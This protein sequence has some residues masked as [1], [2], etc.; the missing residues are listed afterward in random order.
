MSE[1]R[2]QDQRLAFIFNNHDVSPDCF[3]SQSHYLQHL[4]GYE[5]CEAF[6]GP[7][8]DLNKA[9]LHK[10]RKVQK[11][12]NSG[13]E[14]VDENLTLNSA[15]KSFS[16]AL[17]ECQD[18]RSRSGSLL[19]KSDRRKKYLLDLNN[20]VI[21]AKHSSSPR[22]G[23]MK[24]TTVTMCGA[25]TFPSPGTPNYRHSSVGIQKGWSSERV[26][27]YSASN[28][29]SQRNT[30]LLP[31]NTG[32]ALPFKWEDA[33]RWI[34]SPMSGYSS[35]QQPQR[36]PKSKSGPLI[37]PGRA[38]Y[39]FY[40]PAPPVLK[41]GN[42]GDLL[43]DSPFSSGVMA[44]DGLSICTGSNLGGGN[45][46]TNVE[47]CIARSATVHGCSELI[48]L[49]A[50]SE[51]QD[52]ASG[53][54]EDA[55]TGVISRRDMATQMSPEES[56]P[57]SPLRQSSFSHSTPSVLSIEESQSLT[58]SKAQ[59]RDVPVD[60]QV[61]V[62]SWSKRLEIEDWKLKAGEIH[63]S[64]WEDSDTTKSISKIKRE[65][66]KISAWENLQKAKAEAAVRKLEMKLEKKRSSS[67]DKIMKKLRSAQRK[68]K[69]M[70]NSM[71]ASQGSEV[72][73]SADTALS[74]HPTRQLGSLSG[75]F[76]CHAS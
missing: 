24:N 25:G 16:Q 42:G 15:R 74:F 53:V 2:F 33:E 46:P 56:L 22:T 11:V 67:M 4:A 52:E 10:N 50:L 64:S 51:P 63:S 76:T 75:C 44:T 5:F 1:L 71:L 13:A 19:K 34:F 49:S 14:T 61:T 21:N 20:A 43:A 18:R 57:S 62:T 32:R 7:A 29:W 12:Y 45:F 47:P 66:A 73:K 69:E 9:V 70:R 39:S 28:N 31:N 17:K 59:V 8:P 30:A 37:R 27:L 58:S 55:A 3:T 41:G 40:A 48:G 72:A 65:E 68:A 23:V 54:T 38:Y 26:P 35:V 36:R 60:E 6:G